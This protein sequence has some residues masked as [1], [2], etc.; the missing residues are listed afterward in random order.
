MADSDTSEG[1]ERMQL[2]PSGAAMLQPRS[3]H[4]S[5]AMSRAD[6]PV[7]ASRL[8]ENPDRLQTFFNSTTE[9]FLKEQQCPW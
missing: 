8:N 2:G 3:Q 9:R 6:A 1:V 5:N 7:A 4:V